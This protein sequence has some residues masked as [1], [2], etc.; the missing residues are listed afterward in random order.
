MRGNRKGEP[1]FAFLARDP[2]AGRRIS[3]WPVILSGNAA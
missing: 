1:S 3:V 2:L